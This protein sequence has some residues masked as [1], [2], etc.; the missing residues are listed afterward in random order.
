MDT[1]GWH[2]QFQVENDPDCQQILQKH[3]PNTPKWWDINHV[4]GHQLPPAHCIIFGSPCQDLSLAG[5]RAGLTGQQS[6]LYFQATRIIKEMRHATQHTLPQWIIWENVP[7][8]LTSNNGTDFGLALNTLADTGALVIEWAVLDSNQ[9]GIP[10]RRRR[11]YTIAGY[12]PPT[13]THHPT[14]IL[15]LKTSHPRNHKPHTNIIAFYSKHGKYDRPLQ[16]TLPPI[17][18]GTKLNIPTSTAITS[19]T[20]KPRRLTPLEQERAMGWPD[21]HT[22]TTPTGQTLPDTT[23]YKMTGNG[24]TPQTITWIAKHLTPHTHH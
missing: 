11:I 9:F 13:R 8:A 12:N 20:H 21:N 7:G 18:I 10:Q 17:T 3:W 24:I 16:D 5:K 23:R 15:P 1:A 22:Q 4:T 6:N 2:C 14:Q 19:P